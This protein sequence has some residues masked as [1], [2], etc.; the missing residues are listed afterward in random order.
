LRERLRSIAL[1]IAD[2]RQ[3]VLETRSALSTQIDEVQAAI[4]VLQ[5][6]LSELD[7]T[8]RGL[9]GAHRDEA[10]RVREILLVV[11][12]R[13]AEQRSRLHELRASADYELAFTESAPLVTVIVPTYDNYRLLAT[14][15]IPSVQAQT[16]QHFEI[17]VVG[18]A[19]PDEARRVV[20]SIDDPRITFRNLTYRG[21]YS[22]DPRARWHVAG[23]PPYN[24]AAALARGRWIAHLGDDDA[25]RP[26][27]LESLLEAARA[28][29]LELTYGIAN[30]YRPD[31]TT[32][33][34]VGRF[35]PSWG[36]FCMQATIYHAGL[37]PIFPAELSD[38]LF[39]MPWDWAL[40][41]RMLRAG[42]RMGMID[43]IVA[44]GYPSALWS[45]R[46]GASSV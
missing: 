1:S 15:S 36:Q 31:G 18:D 2:T 41:R 35:P 8:V 43:S 42:V 33:P 20:D 16:Y 30:T 6:S 17:I 46:E 26:H 32:A 28:D 29:R 27:H 45:K 37:V 24:E 10:A 4:A 11:R 14:R 3:R 40:C 39:D 9:V 5:D 23:V 21:P 44:D 13:E 7:Q 38:A 12:D 19:A 34:L 25:L 22:D